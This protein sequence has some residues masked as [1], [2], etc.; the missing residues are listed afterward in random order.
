[1]SYHGACTTFQFMEM[2]LPAARRFFFKDTDDTLCA[3]FDD[4]EAK[5]Q[6]VFQLIERHYLVVSDDT[7][8]LGKRSHSNLHEIAS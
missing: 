7:P 6:S 8:V 2:D 3:R 1:M 5:V 4:R